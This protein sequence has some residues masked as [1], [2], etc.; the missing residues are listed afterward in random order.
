MIDSFKGDF[1]WL[2]NFARC[3]IPYSDV[4]FPSVENFYQAMKSAD[5]N[6][7]TQFL[8]ITAKESKKLGR[9][10][11]KRPDWNDIKIGVMRFGLEQKFLSG[12]NIDMERRL[13]NTGGV[14]LVEGNY[15]HDNFWG[16]CT[17]NKCNGIGKNY[18]G[19][20]IMEMRTRL[21][22][23]F[24]TVV[25][26]KKQAYD[27]FIGRPSKWENPFPM[28]GEQDR[29]RVIQE[30]TTHLLAKPEL[31]ADLS[32]LKGMRLGCYCA[33]KPCHGD[34]L[35]KLIIDNYFRGGK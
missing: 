13:Y 26:C 1:S 5:S 31:L 18:L 17:C 25:H 30:F 35:I 14:L 23:S 6:Q 3:K 7:I 12:F 4:V 19:E 9:T 24:G 8:T 20:L 33:P 2:S 21:R 11:I 34:V 27:V 16:N 22:I 29:G 15:W 10:I 28:K 32:E